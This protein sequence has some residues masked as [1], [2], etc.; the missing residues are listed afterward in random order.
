MGY[1]VTSAGSGLLLG[2]SPFSALFS[3]GAL[4]FIAAGLCG[5]A[6]GTPLGRHDR[7]L[8]VTE[9]TRAPATS[10]RRVLLTLS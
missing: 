7:P 9:E 5:L 1:T 3:L 4:L 8:A 10:G 2:H 6:S